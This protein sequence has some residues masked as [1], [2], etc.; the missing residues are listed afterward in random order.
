MLYASLPAQGSSRPRC[1]QRWDRWGAYLVLDEVISGFGRLGQWPG[2]N[3]GV[4]PD[5]V[6]LARAVTSGYLPEVR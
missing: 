6:I 2:S 1:C 3:F 4:S 5:L